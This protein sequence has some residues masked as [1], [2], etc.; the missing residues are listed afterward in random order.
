MSSSWL[1]LYA[2]E[3]ERPYGEEG[4]FGTLVNRTE[5]FRVMESGHRFDLIVC[6]CGLSGVT[7][8]REAALRGAQVLLIEPAYP[9]AT[10]CAWRESVVRELTLSPWGLLRSAGALRQV[11][12]SLAPHLATVRRCDLSRFRRLGARVAA[13]ALRN[14]TKAI[15]TPGVIADIP[16]LDERLLIRELALAARQEG[17]FV[18]GATTAGYVERDVESGTFRLCVRDLL[19]DERVVV[20]GGGLFVDPTFSQPLASRIGTPIT[21]LP[22]GTI[23]HVIVE[24]GVEGCEGSGAVRHF[25]LSG[26]RMGT[27]CEVRPGVLV[28]TLLECGE[29]LS[30]EKI[31][32]RARHLCEASGYTFIGEIGRRRAGCGYGS[33]MGVENRKGILIPSEGAPWNFIHVVEKAL[34][35]IE[36]DLSSQRPRRA[37]PGEWRSGEH[38]E[39]TERARRAGVPE[40]TIDCVI[41][42]WKGRVRYIPEMPG[43]FDEVCPG[44]LRGEIA[45]SVASD[46]VS[47]LEDLLFGSLALHTNPAWRER[48]KPIAEALAETGAVNAQGLDMER[49]GVAQG[50]RNL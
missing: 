44:V 35:F 45:L 48:V 15:N 27:T 11:V 40:S 5:A 12:T 25:E 13:R 33:E 50:D 32:E 8:A 24:C 31:S 21:R 43:A 17:V 49:V 42:R 10:S 20:Q 4:P 38:H 18:L 9:G 29:E 6:G 14:V 30:S 19:S 39:F 3:G 46:H 34:A 16:D 7:V 47:S 28:V 36:D 2:G 1:S 22:Q 23:P 41:E 37:L 26:A